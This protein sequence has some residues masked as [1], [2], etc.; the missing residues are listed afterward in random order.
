MNNR[1]NGVSYWKGKM[2]IPLDDW[3]LLKD[4]SE[5]LEYFPDDFHIPST[6]IPESELQWS[7]GSSEFSLLLFTKYTRAS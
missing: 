6:F 1:K 7:S 5:A 3:T 4:T 2:I